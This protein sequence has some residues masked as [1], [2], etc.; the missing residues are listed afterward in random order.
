MIRNRNN[1]GGFTERDLAILR[2]LGIGGIASLEQ[3]A[4]RF[5]QSSNQMTTAKAQLARL[6][7]AGLLQS[8]WCHKRGR[9]ELVYTLTA[10]G[11]KELPPIVQDRVRPGWPPSGEIVQQLLANDTQALIE[12]ELQM[13]G[14]RIIEWRTARELRAEYGKEVARAN[15]E[16]RNLPKKEIADA[17]IVVQARD[18]SKTIVD[19]EID[20][21]YFGQML[22]GKMKGFGKQKS[23]RVWWV[24][25]AAREN[26]IRAAALPY[27]NIRVL[28]LAPVRVPA[29]EEDASE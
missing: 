19:I 22:E 8:A 28:I 17:E 9:P 29:I 13:E 6:E 5:W 21:Q 1:T 2:W 3:L 12:R 18:G 20:G 23:R 27:R 7:G 4:A 15:Y 26:I 25:T 24:C 11:V 16:G 14:A 10:R